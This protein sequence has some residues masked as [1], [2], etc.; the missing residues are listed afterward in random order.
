MYIGEML[1]EHG[2]VIGVALAGYWMRETPAKSLP[3]DEHHLHRKA[4]ILG[5][6]VCCSDIG[7]SFLAA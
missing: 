1:P 2:T 3:A 7:I 4:T 6:Y 5:S